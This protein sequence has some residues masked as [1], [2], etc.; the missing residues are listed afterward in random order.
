MTDDNNGIIRIDGEDVPERNPYKGL[1]KLVEEF[2]AQH[3]VRKSSRDRY[4]KSLKQFL[5]WAS[6]KQIQQI[7]RASLLEYR[8]TLFEEGKSALTV[9]AYLVS[10]RLFYEYLYQE[11][12]IKNV[13]KGVASPK[14]SNKFEHKA[15][16][17]DECGRLIDYY[18]EKGNLR[19]LA[20]VNLM[21]RTGMRTIEIIRAD[22]GDIGSIGGKRCLFLHGK[23]RDDKKEYV[24]VTDKALDP[25][26]DYIKTRENFKDSDP[27]FVSESRNGK[28]TRLTTKTISLTLRTGLDAIGLRGKDGYTA[29]SCRHSAA[30]I[31]LTRGIAIDRV[32]GVLRH[33]NIATTMGY[34]A[35]ADEKK[36]IDESP[37]SA[38]D[39]AF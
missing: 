26:K 39:D 23:G 11:Y 8:D 6:G 31:M 38:L 16:N 14:R 33:H 20:M 17:E 24:L 25:I 13:A 4:R 18:K 21:L 3:A 27:I 5:N 15:L 9:G 28:G 29:H 34:V 2:L 19:D 32:R 30:S 36:R 22:I 35:M 1:D 10:V 12:D 7:T 37:E